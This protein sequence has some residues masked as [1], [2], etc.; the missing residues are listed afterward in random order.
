MK[1]SGELK[2]SRLLDSRKESAYK[3][4]HW[5]CLDL[6]I[7]HVLQLKGHLRK[8]FSGQGIWVSLNPSSEFEN[9]LCVF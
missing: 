9:Y 5:S 3:V 4:T 1:F 2:L 8:I 6:Y 7:L